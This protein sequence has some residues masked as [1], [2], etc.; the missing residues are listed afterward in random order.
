M[1]LHPV[2]WITSNFL[3]A[4]ILH[5]A[6]NLI[7][8]WAFALVVEGKVGFFPFLAIFL[9]VGFVQCGLEHSWTPR[10][11]IVYGLMAMALV[12]APKN[13]LGCV[14]W[15][16]FRSGLMDMSILWFGGAIVDWSYV[17]VVGPGTAL[18]ARVEGRPK[19]SAIKVHE[20]P[21]NTRKKAAEST[22][23]EDRAAAAT[24]RFQAH[25]ELDRRRPLDP[26]P[27]GGTT[28]EP[29]VIPPPG[30]ADAGRRRRSNSCSFFLAPSPCGDCVA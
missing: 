28:G 8:L 6:G 17:E 19:G 4:N 21:E 29:A 25:L 20:G 9:G 13:E 26:G 24:R 18:Q 27:P 1:Y 2:Q 11:A 16:G 3:H 12:W 30:R 7:F 14:W 15:F 10:S 5:L 22:S 23:P